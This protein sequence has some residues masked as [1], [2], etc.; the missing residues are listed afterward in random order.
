MYRYLF[1]LLLFGFSGKKEKDPAWIR[2]NQL[3]YQPK[4]RK[5]WPYGAAKA[6]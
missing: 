3:G 6:I 5:R 2:I 4:R 1:I